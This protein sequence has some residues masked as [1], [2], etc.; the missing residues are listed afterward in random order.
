MGTTIDWGSISQQFR[1]V[2][3]RELEAWLN[4]YMAGARPPYFQMVPREPLG[5]VGDAS[6]ADV[7][8]S[9]QLT[10]KQ[11]NQYVRSGLVGREL[12]VIP[13]TG[14][15]EVLADWDERHRDT[16][17]EEFDWLPSF[18]RQKAAVG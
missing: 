10:L 9:I 2:H 18:E 16:T 17:L 3:A 13:G 6:M 15:A 11:V 8:T 5:A 12:T 1:R 14:S 4:G 7:V